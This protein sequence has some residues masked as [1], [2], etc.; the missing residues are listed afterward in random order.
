MSYIATGGKKELK[1]TKDKL[2]SLD[3]AVLAKCRYSM[4]LTRV[5]KA[6]KPYWNSNG[7]RLFATTDGVLASIDKL[8]KLKLLERR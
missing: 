7:R 1:E 3:R 6:G 4:N 8:I 5:I 2:N